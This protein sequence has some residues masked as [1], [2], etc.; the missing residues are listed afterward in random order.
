MKTIISAAAA[1]MAALLLMSALVSCGEDTSPAPSQTT[2]GPSD[3]EAAVT[4]SAAA[5]E[6]ALTDA[7]PDL[8]FEGKTLRILYREGNLSEFYAE[9]YTGEVVEDAIR[10]SILAVEARLNLSADISTRICSTY[11]ERVDY[12]KHITQNVM[13]GDDVYAWADI[14]AD[15]CRMLL[16]DGTIA[17]LNTVPYLDFGK[18]WYAGSLAE[19]ASIG[20]GLYCAVGDFSIGY[21]KDSFCVYFN[22]TV[23]Q[24]FGIGDLYQ[25][26]NDGAWTIERAAA[27]TRDAA[28]DLNGDGKFDLEDKLGF[29]LHDKYHLCGFMASTAVPFFTRNAK[30]DWQ[31]TFGTE[32]DYNAV[33]KI[34]RLLVG[35]PGNYL[36]DGTR[37]YTEGASGYRD[38]S[39]K[40]AVGEVFMMTAQMNDAVTELRDMEGDYGILPYPKYDEAQGEYHTSSRTTHSAMVM[41]LIC[42]DREMAGAF[43]EALAFSDYSMVIPAYFELALK[44]KYSRDGESAVM[45][46]IIRDST[47]LSFSYL[48]ANVATQYPTELFISGC[49]EPDKFMSSLAAAADTNK[50]NLADFIAGV[51]AAYAGK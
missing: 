1:G 38:I 16:A 17:D 46:D 26:V 28:A 6:T 41:P 18:P 13:A 34:N 21:L 8:D 37:T 11:T 35:T 22:K 43:L 5:A 7:L 19:E 51:E 45:Y 25:T 23:A 10:D 15:I 42:G 9:E 40:F 48:F 31:Y 30:G 27:L 44:T 4:E 24:D 50:A 2:G 32:H 12:C 39:A 20:G 3:T 49:R 33:S 36:Y 14:M 29:V 47:E